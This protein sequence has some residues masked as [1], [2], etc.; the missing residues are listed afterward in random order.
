MIT[1]SRETDCVRIEVTGEVN[2]RELLEFAQ[3]TVDEWL[4]D[5]VIWDLSAGLI[6]KV[7]SDYDAVSEI[8]SKI[9]DLVERRKNQDVSLNNRLLSVAFL[10]TT[11]RA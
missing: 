9:H 4:V 5:T 3:T 10:Y 1:S 8:V 7:E 6:A 11:E 2:I